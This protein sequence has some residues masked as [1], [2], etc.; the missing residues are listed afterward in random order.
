[1]GQIDGG[2]L[3]AKA[4]KKEG[5]EYVFTL[6][7][8]HI[9]NLYEGCA[10]EGIELIDFRHEQVAAHAAEGWAKVPGKPGVCIVTAGQVLL[11]QL[12]V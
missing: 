1:M 5:V 12:L 7:G 10:D 11:P 2:H 6:N 4:L 3:F 8:G 9:Y